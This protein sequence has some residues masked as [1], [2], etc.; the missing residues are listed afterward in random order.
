[1]ACNPEILKHVPLF[2]L[3]DADETEVLAGQVE[4]KQFARR[5]RIYKIGDPGGRAYVV[6]SGQVRVTT[7]DEDQQ[8][9]LIDEPSAGGFFGF[10]SLLDETP[11]Q[12]GAVALEDTVCLEVDRRD[13]SVLLE[14]KPMAG[15]DMLSVLGR[16]FHAAQNL[17]RTRSMRNPNEVIEEA[18]TLPDRI[19]DGVARFGG[20]W[21][22]II[23]FCVGLAAYSLLNLALGPRAWDHYP[24]V[25]LNLML[26]TLAALQGPIIMMS[27]NRQDAKDRVRGELDYQVNRRAE[28]EIQAL[29]ARLHR[30]DEK[31]DDV[32]DLIREKVRGSEKS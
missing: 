32:E 26:S 21:R 6:V 2:S 12:S 16:H 13:I 29:S 1:M 11:H 17:V 23:S 22:F 8:E 7:I 31:L 19:A 14:R 5:Q 4:L 27:Q 25:L 15:M 10:A 20:S 24:F 3:L 18:S 30:L 9:V 28:A